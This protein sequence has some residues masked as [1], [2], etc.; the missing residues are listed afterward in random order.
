MD[1]LQAA[2]QTSVADLVKND[3]ERDSAMERREAAILT[4][5]ARSESAMDRLEASV[6]TSVAGLVKDMAERDKE[7]AER[8]KEDHRAMLLAVGVATAIISAVLAL[9]FGFLSVMLN[10]YIAL[11]SLDR[12]PTPSP[13]AQP[14]AVIQAP[15]PAQAPQAPATESRQEPSP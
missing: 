5:Q 12:A 11:L 13:T 14:E 2:V 3:A 4:R 6:Q 9:G 8:S 7:A 15:A 1:R 10:M